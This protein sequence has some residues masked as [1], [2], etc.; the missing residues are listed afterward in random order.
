MPP[1]SHLVASLVAGDVLQHILPLSEV[2]ER[3]LEV[4]PNRMLAEAVSPSSSQRSSNR[5]RASSRVLSTR[6]F[7]QGPGPPTVPLSWWA[8]FSRLVPTICSGCSRRIGISSPMGWL[9]RTAA[10]SRNQCLTMAAAVSIVVGL[11]CCR[12]AVPPSEE[13]LAS[14][15]VLLCMK[16][17]PSSS[18]SSGSLWSPAGCAGAGL[19]L[20]G[21]VA[22]DG[23]ALGA[24]PGEGVS[25]WFS[26]LKVG[27]GAASLIRLGGGISC[28]A[29]CSHAVG[30][31][32][33]A[34]GNLS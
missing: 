10:S 15:C 28:S 2:G 29:I 25:E 32:F 26:P 34:R 30:G 16:E 6:R 22:G 11:P 17:Y 19:G 33:E 8:S 27:F 18:S 13:A 4:I 1:L 23:P 20:K 7:L 9:R 3:I 21:L 14:S 31:L 5:M 24:A 12:P